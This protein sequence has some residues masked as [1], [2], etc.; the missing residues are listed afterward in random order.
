[1]EPCLATCENTNALGGK[2]KIEFKNGTKDLRG[3]KEANENKTG[4]IESIDEGR[5]IEEKEAGGKDKENKKFKEE[6]EE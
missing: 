6:E 5:R 3:G 4:K 2:G 1:M